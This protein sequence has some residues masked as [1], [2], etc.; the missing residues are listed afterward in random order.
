M[1]T[2]QCAT[3]YKGSGNMAYLS[4]T[5]LS[6]HRLLLQKKFQGTLMLR[7][8]HDYCWGL[9]A[10]LMLRIMSKE[11]SRMTQNIVSLARKEAPEKL[12]PA[13]MEQRRHWSLKRLARKSQVFQK[14]TGKMA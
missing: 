2:E 7:W 10:R 8:W 9:S 13:K 1:H 11:S 3:D 14:T 6:G 4:K 5:N 12:Q